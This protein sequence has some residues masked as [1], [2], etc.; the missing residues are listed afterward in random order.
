M[1]NNPIRFPLFFGTALLALGVIHAQTQVDLRTQ[2]KSVDFHAASSTR[3]LQSG[4]TLPANCVQNELFFLTSAP[5]GSNIYGCIATDNWVPEGVSGTFTIQNG[6]VT[7]GARQ[8]Q[9]FVTGSG[10]VNVLTD[11]GNKINIQ[12]TVDTALVLTKPA[13]QSG[14]S[15]VCRA[16]TDT[17]PAF[18]CAM[19]PALSA[20][21]TGMTVHWIPATSAGGAGVSLNIDLLGGKPV[22]RADG[23]TAASTGD[24]VAGQ[25]Y[26]IW[27]DGTAFRLPG[28]SVSGGSGGTSGA[29]AA[30]TS[31][32]A[33]GPTTLI[34]TSEWH[35]S[36]VLCAGAAGPLLTWDTPPGAAT[37]ATPGGCS[38]TG[39]NDGYA[40][41]ANAGNPSLET[42]F[43]LPGTLTGKVDAYIY[44][45]PSTSG[46]TF[47]P[48]LD[49][50]C[51]PSDGSVANDGTFT[52]GGFFAPGPVI[53]PALA[54]SLARVSGLALDW[55]SSCQAGSRAHL[56]IARGDT[57]GTATSLNV[58]EVVLVLRRAM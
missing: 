19:D 8:T 1:T 2:S 3:P 53:S 12:Q 21:S 26:P 10:L 11:L 5:A 48:L 39:T 43:I 37:P 50:F 15:L 20:Y 52:A 14:A 29:P 22:L 18:A 55:P 42:S 34:A 4:T 49:L 13:I 30:I 41:F 32:N 9:N 40:S 35:S 58:A 7:V 31:A 54:G 38:G 28:A 6:G 17:A 23:L 46:G 36:L 25:M 16:A 33:G 51:T 57:S 44:Y 47:T 27:Y 24:V 45:L 56:R